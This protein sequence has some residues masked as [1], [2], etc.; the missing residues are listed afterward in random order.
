M[1]TLPFSYKWSLIPHTHLFVLHVTLCEVKLWDSMTPVWGTTDYVMNAWW[2]VPFKLLLNR[3][4]KWHLH[5]QLPF[6]AVFW[7]VGL[8]QQPNCE[9]LILKKLTPFQMGPQWTS[10]T[11]RPWT[12]HFGFV[13]AGAYSPVL[14]SQLSWLLVTFV[15]SILS[16]VW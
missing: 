7:L 9:S 6:H 2:F 1:V 3:I 15:K 13:N 16:D 14:P 11:V 12:D 4:Q 8:H 5:L 10:L